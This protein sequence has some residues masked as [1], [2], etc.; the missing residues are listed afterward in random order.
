M[1]LK[2]GFIDRHVLEPDDP[3]VWLQL[4][5]PI[6]QQKGIPVRQNGLNFCLFHHSHIRNL[7]IDKTS[8]DPT[9]LA[10]YFLRDGG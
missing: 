4:L 3:P 9:K 8:N 6:D 10:R 7:L 5:H 2:E 1:P